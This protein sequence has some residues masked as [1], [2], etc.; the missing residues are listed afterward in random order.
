VSHKAFITNEKTKTLKKRLSELVEHSEELKFLVGFFYFSGWSQIYNSLKDRD[1]LEIKVLVGLSVDKKLYRIMEYAREADNLTGEDKADDFFKSLKTAINSEQLDNEEFY[2]QVDF[3]AKLIEQDKLK[4]KKTQEPNHAKLYIFKI[5]EHLKGIANCK[6]I[7]GSSNLTKA[8][9]AE[10][11]EFNV[12]IGDYG[13]EEAEKYFDELWGPAIEITENMQRK[14][15]LLDLIRNR[16]QAAIVTPFEAY[17]KVLKTYIDLQKQRQIKPHVSR[18][19]EEKGYK[20]Y[21]YQRDAVNQALTIIE[22]YNGVIIADVVGLGKSVIA[23]MIAK[24]MGKRGMIIC[25][26]GIIGDKSIPSGW[27]KYKYDFQ[28]YDWEIYSSGDLENAVKYLQQY[29]EDIEVVIV[30]EAHRYRNQDT[31]SY[32]LLSSICRKRQVMLLTATPFNNSP[33]DIFSLL[34]LFIVPGKS[35]ITLDENLEAR[36]SHYEKLFR[37]LSFITKNHN[38][39]NEEKRTKAEYYFKQLF[40]FLPIDMPFVQGMSHQLASQIREVLEPI[41][42]RRNRLDLKKDP[43]YSRE[44]IELS[45]VKNP[46]ELFFDLTKEQSEFYDEV[47]EDYF[48]DNGRF[49]GA[50][51]Q[52]FSYEMEIDEDKLDEEGNRLFQ[53]QRNLFD[54]MR[55]LLVKRFESSFGSFRQSID[56][57]LN[58]HDCVKKFV[59]KTKGRYVLERK[60]VE[61]AYENNPDE[62]EE[63]LLEYAQRLEEVAETKHNRV[64]EVNEFQHK[65]Q[66]YK[67]IDSDIKLFKEVK[68]KIAKLKLV[69]NDPKSRELIEAINRIVTETPSKNHPRRKVIIFTEYTDT[70]KHLQPIIEKLF[71]NQVLTIS[72]T[73]SKKQSEALLY[74]FDAAVK[75]KHQN[76][77]FSILLTSDKLSE[78]YNLNRAGAI[79]NYDIPWNPTRVI[80]RVG[81]INRIG[82]KVFDNLYIYNFFPTEQGS[83][84]V[85]SRQIASQKMFLIHNTL[86]EDCKI[87]DADE[88]PAPAELYKRINTNPE[89]M[90]EENLLT[91]IRSEYNKIEKEHPEVINRVEHLPNRIKTAKG[92]DS[93]NLVVF[94]RKALGLFIQKSV[95]DKDE[96]IKVEGLLIDDAIRHIRCSCDEKRLSLSRN[97]WQHYEK[98][99]EHKDK[100]PVA[101]NEISLEVKAMNNLQSALKHYMSELEKYLPFIRDLIKDLRNYH[102]IPKYSVRRIANLKLDADR[103]KE[104]KKFIKELEL[105]ISNLGTDY[106]EIV[107]KRVKDNRDEI[108]IAV[109]NIS[110]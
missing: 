97:F 107:E 96:N 106:L 80:Q 40:G 56:N 100:F 25:P 8:G 42:I 57:F 50:I 35:M 67:N 104:L 34:K 105:L 88:I 77:N 54:F 28:L 32:E 93:Y 74:D 89:E 63:A 19:L 41:M 92:F 52:P 37:Q 59:E 5:K 73:I 71:S 108:I 29:G 44:V 87:F 21:S 7:T 94:R 3:F 27:N 17:V 30:D 101:T 4:I 85:K 103:P 99:K 24:N 109:E 58:V 72:G 66:F 15:D 95:I 14:R 48:G 45:E 33:A 75:P 61:K 31:Q 23:S 13:T 47:I 70:V 46:E 98:I 102:T 82:Q 55:R 9:I 81:R 78:G 18:L 11:N 26:P 10:Q 16:S 60:I 68:A 2:R 53:Q 83:D 79:I 69:E 1:D 76:D 65:D 20:S 110:K 36:F 12:E 39:T 64:Y 84:V 62:L 38:S 22:N 90:E 91:K 51:Y 86:G 49:T 6:F 43:V